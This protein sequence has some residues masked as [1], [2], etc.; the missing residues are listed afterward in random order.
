VN[1]AWLYVG[2]V[3][4]AAVALARRAGVALPRRIA[5]LFYA[6][7]LLFLWKPLTGPYVNVAPD[8]L[9]LIPPW[10]AS[11][12][13][14]FDKFDVSNY[15]LQD[16][17]FQFIP[18][19]KQVHESWRALKPPLWNPLAACGMPLLPNMQGG[20]MSPLRLLTIGL[21]LPYSF[22]AEGALKILVALTFAFLYCRRRYALLPSAIGAIAFGFGTFITLWLHFPHP[23]V[24]AFLPAVL[25]QIDLLAERVTRGRFLFAAFLGPVLLF[26]GH[27]ESTAH[28]V[29]FAALYAPWV[30]VTERKWR[31]VGTL[32]AVSLV[33]L[34]LAAPVLLPFAE[35]LP[36]STSYAHAREQ[37]HAQA[38]AFSDFHSLALLVHPRLYGE[39]PGPLWGNAVTE[40][41]AG[42]AGLL[43]IGAFFGM[44][45]RGRFREREGFF[46]LATILCF[47]VVADV[48]YLS[49]PVKQLFSIALNSRFRLLLAFCLAVQTAALLHERKRLQLAVAIAGAL[50][51]LGYVMVKTPFPTPEA[52]QFA[53]YATIPSVVVLALA[54]VSSRG[55]QTARDPLP[56]ERVSIIGGGSR[57]EARD[58]TRTWALPLLVIAVYAELWSAGHS[59]HPPKRQPDIYPRTPILDALREQHGDQPYRF[60]GIGPVLFP[61][62]HAPFGFEDVRVKDAL[63]SAKY[64]D[65]LVREVKGFD[66]RS[67]YMKWE[68]TETPL[69]DRLNVRWLMTEPKVELADRARYRPIYEG[70]DGRIYENLRVKPRFFGDGANVQVAR[71][72]GD[73]YEL[74]VDAARETLVSSSVGW[75]PGWRVTH[76]GRRLEPR[77]VDEA[78]LGFTVPPGRGTVRMR[79]VPLSFW[80]GV[81]LSLATLLAVVLLYHPRRCSTRAGST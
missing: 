77:V 41:V 63:S 8:V 72:T 27:P 26:G 64:V 49:A 32:V 68:D 56:T 57:A 62:T 21:P 19:T 67:Y 52:K 51:V 15:E 18:W 65:L 23:N 55:A 5:L 6:L 36:H 47:A 73:A 45:V 75:W 22:M 78:F 54:A 71:Y 24:A 35:I 14:G 46:V 10:S 81:A 48:P 66:I 50:G 20:A 43:G 70:Y 12:P 38:T 31:L 34:L 17:V 61:N 4:A 58:D 25:Y 80:L 74:R 9:L 37:T 33:S 79:Y 59:W 60:V 28:V 11:A 76:N 30:I 16:I 40:T 3:Y 13:E 39:R 53:L 29:F 44:L 7:V 2:V 1:L 42:F 69:L